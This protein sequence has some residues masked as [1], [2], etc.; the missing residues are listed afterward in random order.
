MAMFLTLEQIERSLPRLSEVHNFFGMSYLAFKRANIPEGMTT[1]VV[2]SQIADEILEKYYKPCASYEGYYNPFKTSR[3]EQRWNVPR[4][5]STSLQRINDTF[6][7]ALIHPKGSSDWGWKKGYVNRLKKK[8]TSGRVPA[9]D[10]AA[11][12]FRNEEWPDKVTPDNVRQR[13]FQ[14]FSISQEEVEK[15]FDVSDPPLADRWVGAKS[16]ITEAELL[17]LLGNPPGA[18]P[19]EGAAISFLKLREIGPATEFDY[20][21]AD[22][23]NIITGDNSLGKTFILECIWWALTGGWPGLPVLPRKSAPKSKPLISF[24][25]RTMGGNDRQYE[26]KYNW[27]R[28]SWI[29]PKNR[30]SLPGL[31]IYARFDGSFAVWDPARTLQAEGFGLVPPKGYIFLSSSEIWEGLPK[32]GVAGRTQWV[33]NG[34][35]RDWV[36]WQTSKRFKDHYSSLVACLKTLSPDPIEPLFPGEPTRLPLDSREIPTLILPYGEVPVLHAS[37]GIQ[38]VIGLCY[39]MVWAWHEHLMHSDM[40]RRQPQRRLVLLF[41]E[42]EAHLHPRWQRV[43]VPGLMEAIKELSTALTPQI[44]IATHSPMVMASAEPLFDETTDDLHHLKL[45]GK[46]VIL[47]ELPFVRRGTADRWLMSDVFALPV[48]RSLPAE[49]AITDAKG[50]QAMEGTEVDQVAV[51]QVHDRLVKYLAPDDTFWPRWTSFAERYGV[52]Q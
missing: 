42:V 45:D 21:P 20:E 23:L 51:R 24:R 2:F 18:E 12:L 16:P 41:D 34:L 27:D 11:W 5:A 44:H 46:E 30:Q 10:L 50:I 48:A 35:L 33:C 15:L 32:D 47:E 19:E 17:R 7:D 49:K 9:F 14:E 52:E 3:R 6:A 29:V 1:H 28:Q 43:I 13:L 22:R 8:L 31:V 40:I 26:A 38:R 36:S 25:I 37:A 4:Y 39:I